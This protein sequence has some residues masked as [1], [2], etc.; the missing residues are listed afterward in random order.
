MTPTYPKFEPSH[1]DGVYKTTMQMFNKRQD[2]EYY[3]IGV[4][5]EEWNSIAFVSAYQIFKIEYLGHVMFDVYVR[6]ADIPK[7]EYICSVSKLRKDAVVRTAVSSK[8]CSRIK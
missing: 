4:F 8:I 7:V 5:D 6:K 3:E 2:V 1:L